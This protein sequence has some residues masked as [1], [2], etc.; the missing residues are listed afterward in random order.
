MRMRSEKCETILLAN[1][2]AEVKEEEETSVFRVDLPRAY[3]IQQIRVPR[4]N[5]IVH[6]SLPK[7]DNPSSES[8][9][10]LEVF[11]LDR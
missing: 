6:S 2:D 11:A 10:Q 7:I 3:N 8:K 4:T 5:N 9:P 1:I